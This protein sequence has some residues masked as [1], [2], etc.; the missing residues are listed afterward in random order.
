MQIA[1][2]MVN[3]L[4]GVLRDQGDL[5]GASAAFERARP[6]RRVRELLRESAAKLEMA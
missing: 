6:T 3:D 4:G 1:N 2:C 5:A